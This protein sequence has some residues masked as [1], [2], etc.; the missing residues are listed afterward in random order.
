MMPRRTLSGMRTLC[1]MIVCSSSSNS[2]NGCCCCWPRGRCEEAA[3]EAAAE[4]RMCPRKGKSRNGIRACHADVAGADDQ[5]L[6]TRGDVAEALPLEESD[7]LLQLR[8]EA[9]AALLGMQLLLRG[10]RRKRQA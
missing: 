5:L 10:L 2:C 7:L 4:R 8:V 1:G 9:A 3:S 6:D